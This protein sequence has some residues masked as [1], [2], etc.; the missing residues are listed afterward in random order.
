MI[1]ATLSAPILDTDTLAPLKRTNP[2]AVNYK[3]SV[4]ELN[5]FIQSSKV[6][7]NPNFDIWYSQDDFLK[8]IEND[9]RLKSTSPFAINMKDTLTFVYLN[10]DLIRLT[11]NGDNS[12]GMS[13][14]KL[15]AFS[16]GHETNDVRSLIPDGYQQLTTALKELGKPSEYGKHELEIL[17]EPIVNFDGLALPSLV[18]SQ[19]ATGIFFQDIRTDT[20]GNI[21]RTQISFNKNGTVSRADRSTISSNGKS[22]NEPKIE[23]PAID[24]IINGVFE[25]LFPGAKN[26][27]RLFKSFNV[28][29]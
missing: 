25:S 27:N 4:G 1:F 8:I 9:V 7:V 6:E 28:G 5:K 16:K 18:V 19:T 14:Q 10:F 29:G 20:N 26:M 13:L 24:R 2:A 17:K 11:E 22:L 12:K 3:V 21:T 15:S 23:T